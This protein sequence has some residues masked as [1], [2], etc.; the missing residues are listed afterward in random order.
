MICYEI[1][2]VHTEQKLKQS[3]G[4]QECCPEWTIPLTHGLR[5]F[6]CPLQSVHSI[7]SRISAGNGRDTLRYST[8]LYTLALMSVKSITWRFRHIRPK[9]NVKCDSSMFCSCEWGVTHW[10]ANNGSG[11]RESVNATILTL[12][13]LYRLWTTFTLP[14][15]TI[16]HVHTSAHGV[17]TLFTMSSTLIFRKGSITSITSLECWK[18]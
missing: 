13:L 9:A 15:C 4:V 6:Q 14:K 1:N 8:A 7:Y 11:C 12:H 16:R 5:T 10:N 3:C 2:L 18:R 17:N